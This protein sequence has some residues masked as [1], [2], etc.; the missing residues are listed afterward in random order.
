MLRG[1][2]IKRYSYAF[3]D[4]W[5]LFIPWHFPLHKNTAIQGNSLEA[6]KEFEKQYPA[7]Y[8]HLLQYKD[9]LLARN[10][11]ET[12]IRY[13]WYA[14]QRCAATYYQNFDKP[15]IIY[16]ETQGRQAFSYDQKLFYLDKTAFCV[17]SDTVRLEILLSIFSSKIIYFYIKNNFGI[18]GNCANM[19]A[20]IYMENLPIP[21]PNTKQEQ[22]I[23]ELVQ[24]ILQK[25]EQ[26]LPTDDQ[27]KEIDLLVYQLYG[28]TEEE[29]QF[30]EN[31]FN[32]EKNLPDP[33]K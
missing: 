29:I 19:Y 27:E 21:M 6:E 11:A 12:G 1:R 14:L 8:K 24:T 9:Q 33:L 23:T 5:L 26:S 15:K 10:K 7:I 16:A 17:T 2:D 4:K 25:K 20:K 28:L 32:Q 13:E 31:L 30:V 22:Q 18:L 3:A